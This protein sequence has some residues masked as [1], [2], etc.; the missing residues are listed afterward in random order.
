M[1]SAAMVGRQLLVGKQRIAHP[2]EKG[3][4]S[5]VDPTNRHR[6]WRKAIF[7]VNNGSH[8]ALSEY[9]LDK[10]MAIELLTPECDK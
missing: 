2:E 5:A 3:R 9:G 6:A 8:C 1:E 7:I 4:G 10:L